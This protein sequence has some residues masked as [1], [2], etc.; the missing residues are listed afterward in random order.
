M[1]NVPFQK[2]TRVTCRINFLRNPERKS[3]IVDNLSRDLPSKKNNNNKSS[4]WQTGIIFE[5]GATS[6]QPI[7]ILRVRRIKVQRRSVYYPSSLPALSK[8][9]PKLYIWTCCTFLTDIF[10]LLSLSLR[11]YLLWNEIWWKER[12]G[13]AFT[14]STDMQL[15]S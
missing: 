1:V 6:L 7:S 5:F 8:T 2:C 12:Y 14:F 10:P 4:D 13:L 15:M 9:T 3:E 11:F